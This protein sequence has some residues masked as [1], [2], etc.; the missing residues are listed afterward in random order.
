MSTIM[1][2]LCVSVGRTATS[3]TFLHHLELA[4][5]HQAE[6][7]GML[8]RAAS[9]PFEWQKDSTADRSRTTSTRCPSKLPLTDCA[10]TWVQFLAGEA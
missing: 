2:T 1:A 4:Y 3:R 10:R 6:I 9:V 7:H 8:E 5:L